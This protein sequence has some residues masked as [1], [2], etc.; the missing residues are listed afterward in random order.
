MACVK[1]NIGLV[2]IFL[3]L[4]MDFLTLMICNFVENVV[5]LKVGGAFGFCVCA[6]ALYLAASQFLNEDNFWFNLPVGNFRRSERS[7]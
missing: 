7:S 5:A 6:S 4:A 2:T 1:A 3:L